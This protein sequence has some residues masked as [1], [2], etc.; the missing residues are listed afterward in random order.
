MTARHHDQRG[1]GTVLMI[2]VML[3]AAMVAFVGACLLA[4]FGCVHKA[5][6]AA[7][8]AAVAGADAYN[9]GADA[10]SAASQAAVS[11]KAQLTACRVDTN[12]YDFIVRVTVQVAASPHLAFGPDHFEETSAA[13]NI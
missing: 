7:D 2:A 10:C 5:R 8:L 4:W 9:T 6:A 3:I 1:S 11:N 12:G 13:G